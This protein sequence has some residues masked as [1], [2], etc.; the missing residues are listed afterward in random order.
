M[1]KVLPSIKTGE[2]TDEIGV[3]DL[4]TDHVLFTSYVKRLI[5]ILIICNLMML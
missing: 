2:T 5:R 1:F 4:V 3:M